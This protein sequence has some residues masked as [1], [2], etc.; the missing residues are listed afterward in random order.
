[1]NPFIQR[2]LDCF[3]LREGMQDSIE[4]M[5]IIPFRSVRSLRPEVKNCSYKRTNKRPFKLEI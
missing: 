5:D 3:I 4:I 2:K 1:M